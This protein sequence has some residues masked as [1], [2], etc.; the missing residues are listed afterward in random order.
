MTAATDQRLPVRHLRCER[1]GTTFVCGAGGRSGC[2]CADEPDRL[3]MPPATAG[4]CLCPACL[5]AVATNKPDPG[6]T[7]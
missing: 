4:D 2:W 3:P 1:C 5:R 7:A 6:S